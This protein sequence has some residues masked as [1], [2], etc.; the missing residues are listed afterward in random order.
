M[1]YRTTAM[2]NCG[3][4]EAA[5]ARPLPRGGRPLRGLLAARR[6]RAHRHLVAQLHELRGDGLTDDARAQDPDAHGAASYYTYSSA[7]TASS[8]PSRSRIGEKKPCAIA[9]GTIADRTTTVTAARTG[10][11]R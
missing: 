8:R 1:R 2:L 7:G 6:A 9:V 4:R 11:G 3:V 10:S 5:L